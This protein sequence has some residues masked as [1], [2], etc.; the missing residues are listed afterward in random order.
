MSSTESTTENIPGSRASISQIE[1][2]IPIYKNFRETGDI[3]YPDIELLDNDYM[4]EKAY[5]SF[6]GVQIHRLVCF[7]YLHQKCESL[8]RKPNYQDIKDTFPT[9]PREECLAYSQLYEE[10]DDPIEVWKQWIINS[11]LPKKKNLATILD[12]DVIL[13]I[14][15]AGISNINTSE[16][17][18][19]LETR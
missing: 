1:Q 17:V 19:N 10:Y 18:E 8:Y 14:W 7:L 2:I 5:Y 16:I 9:F 13:N 11:E 6:R 15:E 4:E 12:P 3:Q